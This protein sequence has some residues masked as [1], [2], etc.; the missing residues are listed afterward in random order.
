MDSKATVQVVPFARGGKS[1]TETKGC[2]H[3]FTP[4]DT[5]TPVEIFLPKSDELFIYEVTSKVTSDCLVDC[6]AQWWKTV[7]P[8]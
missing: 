3:D 1:R 4:E 6:L 5:V 2:D 7:Q 8:R